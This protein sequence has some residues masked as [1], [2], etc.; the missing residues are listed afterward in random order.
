MSFVTFIIPTIGRD[1]LYRTLESLLAQTVTDWRAI[2]VVDQSGNFK[3]P[4]DDPRIFVFGLIEKLGHGHCSGQVRNCGMALGGSTWCGFVDD[5][6]RLDTHY[7]EWL[8]Q[9]CDGND[10][11][12]FK[13]R[14]SPPREDAIVTLPR[15]TDVAG[16]RA[17]EVGISFAVRTEFQ[18]ERDV[19]FTSEEFEDWL[20]IKRC[21]DAGARCKISEHVAYYVRH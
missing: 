7:V 1:T 13:M 5:D 20:F 16:L 12:I 3:L 14:Y 15:T 11:H 19:W 6:D 18:Q 8:G 9:E 2:V 4:L 17:A 21:L 10:L